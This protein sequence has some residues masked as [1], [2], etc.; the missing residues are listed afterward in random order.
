MLNFSSGERQL[1]G[2][3]ARG[4]I[5]RCGVEIDDLAMLTCCIDRA[6]VAAVVKVSSSSCEKWESALLQCLLWCHGGVVEF[7]R[8]AMNPKRML[9]S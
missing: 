6:Q 1:T 4:S 3:L 5:R 9:V 2:E 7:W 8:C